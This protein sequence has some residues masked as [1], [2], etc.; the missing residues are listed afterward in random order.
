MTWRRSSTRSSWIFA[1]ADD[2]AVDELGAAMNH[3]EMPE[4]DRIEDAG[5]DGQ[6]CRHVQLP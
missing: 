1:D 4:M 5:V 2:Q 3:V 6:S